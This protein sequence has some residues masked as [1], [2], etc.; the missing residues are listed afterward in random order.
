MKKSAVDRTEVLLR[1]SLAED[2]LPSARLFCRAHGI[3][4]RTY[5]AALARL[6]AQGIVAPRRG[7]APLSQE[8]VQALKQSIRSGAFPSLAPLPSPKELSLTFH[9]HPVTIRRALAELTEEGVLTRTGRR[10]SL[11][12]RSRLSTEKV[13]IVVC[14]GAQMDGEREIDTWREV[15]T[16]AAAQGLAVHMLPWDGQLGEIPAGTIG[17]IVSTW[18]L[19]DSQELLRQLVTRRLRSCIWTESVL[20]HAVRDWKGERLLSFHDIGNSR[21]AGR[22][23]ARHLNGLG[24]RHLAWLSPFHGS[25]WS[26]NRLEGLRQE[27]S[28]A[29]SSFVLKSV[30]EGDFMPPVAETLARWEH[31]FE[32]FGPW[33]LSPMHPLW[34]VFKMRTWDNLMRAFEPCLQEALASGATVW[35]GASD[36]VASLCRRWLLQRSLVV[37]RDLSLCGFDDTSLSIRED[38]TSYRFDAAAMARAMIRSLLSDRPGEGRR[39]SHSG[40]VVARGSTAA[41]KT[42]L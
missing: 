41:P 8:I 26:K 36:L 6:T 34:E 35:V 22:D 3:S 14:I 15:Q 11:A 12:R 29:V 40:R 28:G 13:P 16:E 33:S 20:D 19:T 32:E 1:A 23:M 4:S 2:S 24:H 17:A 5:S 31:S 18:H 38:L 25:L 37:P 39:T 7:P 30:S 21:V 42:A 27:F 9:V 10:W